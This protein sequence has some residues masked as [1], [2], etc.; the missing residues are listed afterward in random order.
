MQKFRT[1]VRAPNLGVSSSSLNFENPINMLSQIKMLSKKMNQIYMERLVTL[2]LIWELDH[3]RWIQTQIHWIQ[4]TKV[5]KHYTK[6]FMKP[7]ICCVDSKRKDACRRRL[8]RKNA[9][10]MQVQTFQRFRYFLRFRKYRI[11]LLG[12]HRKLKKIRSQ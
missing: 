7:P 2:Q 11:R 5:R 8:Q 12:S 10:R 6:T 4:T 3:R 9:C 1:T